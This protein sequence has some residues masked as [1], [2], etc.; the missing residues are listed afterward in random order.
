M[1]VGKIILAVATGAV[2]EVAWGAIILGVLLIES[3][4][5]TA[6][7]PAAAMVVV[8]AESMMVVVVEA[9]QLS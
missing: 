1:A 3:P 4:Q 2:M 8:V 9:L 7:V 5:L 6:I